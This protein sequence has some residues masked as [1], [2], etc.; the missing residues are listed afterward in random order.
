[1]KILLI[2]YDDYSNLQHGFASA[3]K[4]IGEDVTD[5]K[6]IKH[7]F[8]YESQSKV[9]TEEDMKWACKKADLI[10]FFHSNYHIFERI[11][12]S[13]QSKRL[14][15]IHTGSPYRSEPIKQNLIFNP[16]C[17]RI[18]SDQCEFMSLGGRGIKYIAGAVDVKAM[19]PIQ[20]T[21]KPPYIF[22][23]YPSNEE[24]KGTAK[25]REVLSEYESEI[26][27]LI[28]GSRVSHTVNLKRL[29]ECDIYVEMFKPVL[30][31][32]PYGV[33]GV[34]AFEAA[35]MGKV[36]ITQNIYPNVYK[37]AYGV[38][39]PFLIANTEKHFHDIIQ[40]L[41]SMPYHEIQE[42]QERTRKWVVKYHSMEATGNY[43]MNLIEGKIKIP[44]T[45][46]V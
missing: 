19:Q 27:L 39:H 37:Q 35:A 36:V 10:L 33:Y 22:A 43:L 30:N 28:D 21:V 20:K 23:H 41:I 4:S 3:L 2:C 8:E 6:L 16:Y 13:M 44:I 11:K 14:I 45:P 7:H 9:V 34:S 17:E 38:E 12:W 46:Y 24:V 18:L 29:S 15:A 42:I 26:D 40:S 25:I 32:N 31:D 1:M 5:L